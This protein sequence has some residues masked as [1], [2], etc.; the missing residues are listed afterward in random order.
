MFQIK[1][2][3]DGRNQLLDGLACSDSRGNPSAPCGAAGW[4]GAWGCCRSRLSRSLWGEVKGQD[5]A[6][7]AEVQPCSQLLLPLHS[8]LLGA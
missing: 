2:R 3:A 5:V 8:H 4:T 7:E 1:C 6:A